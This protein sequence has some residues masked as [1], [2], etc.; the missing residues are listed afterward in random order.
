MSLVRK[1]R[2]RKL[3]KIMKELGRKKRLKMRGENRKCQRS[4]IRSRGESNSTL[5]ISSNI[6]SSNSTRSS[7]RKILLKDEF[8]K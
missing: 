7:S 1:I 6:S 8:I 4:S 3:I 2:K 5:C